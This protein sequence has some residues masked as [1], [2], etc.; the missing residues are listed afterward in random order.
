MCP[1]SSAHF[2]VRHLCVEWN[3]LTVNFPPG[4]SFTRQARNRTKVLRRFLWAA[5][6]TLPTS[7]ESSPI[8]RALGSLGEMNAGNIAEIN[9]FSCGKLIK[10]TICSSRP[11]VL[12]KLANIWGEKSGASSR[13]SVK[14][15]L[16]DL[17]NH[18]HTLT[19]IN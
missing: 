2:V 9:V 1:I 5:S 3:T 10:S 15:P 19:H 7:S 18:K 6:L 13:Y 17:G 8:V 14:H 11:G 12:I 4:R 16:V